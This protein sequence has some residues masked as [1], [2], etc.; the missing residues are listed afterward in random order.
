[1]S[2]RTLFRRLPR[3]FR[4]TSRSVLGASALC[5]MLGACDAPVDHAV[6]LDTT[7]A[8]MTLVRPVRLVLDPSQRALDTLRRGSRMRAEV[9]VVDGYPRAVIGR[10]PSAYTHQVDAARNF[11]IEHEALFR[12]SRDGIEL[13]VR[14]L[15]PNG[16][17]VAFYQSWRGLPLFGAELTVL[18]DGNHVIGTV[19]SLAVEA[20]KVDTRPGLTPEQAV[21]ILTR[22]ARLGDPNLPTSVKLGVVGALTV[23]GRPVEARLAYAVDLGDRAYTGFVDATTG[24]VL[25]G[26]SQVHPLDPSEWDLQLEDANGTNATDSKCFYFTTADDY[27]GDEYGIFPAYQDDIGMHRLRNAAHD[28]W[29]FYL[30]AFG[31]ESYDDDGAQLEV[32]NDVGMGGSASWVAPCDVIQFRRSAISRDIMTHEMTHGVIRDTSELVYQDE[33]GAV[34]EMFADVLGAMHDRN[35]TMGEET[36]GGAFRDYSVPQ[37]MAFYLDTTEDWGGVHT[38][39]QIG[40]HAFFLMTMG[41]TVP[42]S[43]I[44]GIGFDKAAQLAYAAMVALPSNATFRDVAAMT[45]LYAMGWAFASLNGFT[46]QNACDVTN[47]WFG[48][49]AGL[50]DPDCDGVF[51]SVNDSDMDGVPDQFDNCVSVANPDQQELAPFNGKGDA[52]DPDHDGD[53]ILNTFDNC[54]RKANPDQ[55]DVLGADG[56][57]DGI[58]DA[59]QDADGDGVRDD[60][61]N[62]PFDSNPGQKDKDNDG[63]GDVCDFDMDKDGVDDD[64]DN[65]IGVPNPDQLNSDGD[66]I[67]DACDLCVHHYDAM[68]SYTKGVPLLDI[69][70][71]PVQADGD[72]DGIGDACDPNPFGPPVRYHGPKWMPVPGAEPFSATL[73]MAPGSIAS[74]DFPLCDQ[75]CLEI[76]DY[77]ALV[78]L[79][80][81]GLPRTISAYVIEDSGR[82]AARSRGGDEARTLRLSPRGG[83][84]YR[85]VLVASDLHRGEE[86]TILVRSDRTSRYRTDLDRR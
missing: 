27:A 82:L 48:V 76:R 5:A 86:S 84:N 8:A 19:G 75:R 47:A 40:S 74:F 10:W 55:T 49:G 43:V 32:Y 85:L 28:S 50:A 7:E 1:M 31:R 26:W 62:C 52:C 38:N 56:Q 70:P 78:E 81:V 23:P 4:M 13:H 73:E 42:G 77:D 61:D 54:P 60:G 45:R 63:V 65:C 79:E 16:G 66:W 18:M 15:L 67:G 21:A 71:Q 33:S 41:G 68:T 72:K 9:Q 6:E 59:C 29:E 69:P 39:S 17:G 34:N 35:W 3:L 30:D 64:V 24:D 53:G 51:S 58:G 11:L 83:R 20:P 80:L 14:R 44:Q 57:P 2:T 36:D 12:P 37:H 46:N 25:E 22:H